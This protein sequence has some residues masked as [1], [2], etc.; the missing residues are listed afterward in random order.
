M[1]EFIAPV[2][3]K[4]TEILQARTPALLAAAQRGEFVDWGHAWTGVFGGIPGVRVSAVRSEFDPE[5]TPCHAR[6]QARIK[7][8]VTGTDPDDVHAA[9]IA[10]VKAVHLALAASWPGDW[11][12]TPAGGVTIRLFVM[13]HDYG[14][15]FEG[16]GM[17]VKFPEMDVLVETEENWPAG[18]EGV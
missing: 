4:L 7:L 1:P 9:A 15:L 8:A 2:I 13:G 5:S 17:V 12:G 3:A 11:V 6:H 10:Y 18:V 16:K 14:P